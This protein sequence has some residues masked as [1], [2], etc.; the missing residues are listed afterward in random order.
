MLKHLLSLSLLAVTGASA[1][2]GEPSD[3][4]KYFYDDPGSEYQLENRDRF[5]G[6]M[7]DYLNAV[8]A[9]WDRDE[10]ICVDFVFSIDGQDF[11]QEEISSSLKL[12]ETVSGDSATVVAHFTNFEQ[13]SD[14]EWTLRKDAGRWLVSDIASLT[15]NWRV[16]SMTCE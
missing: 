11:D 7:L 8:N 14:I 16:S 9:A 6:P 4:V 1:M 13:P 3:A 15:T 10:T 2:A 5:T 12:D